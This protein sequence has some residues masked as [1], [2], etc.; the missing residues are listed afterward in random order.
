MSSYSS[1][2]ARNAIVKRNF[3]SAQHHIDY[4]QRITPRS[5]ELEALKKDLS[6]SQ[7]Q[8]A[9]AVEI[10]SSA[11]ALTV[12]PYKKPRFLGN[13][14]KARE[15]LRKAF[16]KIKEAREVDP[17]NPTLKVAEQK[18]VDKYSN[19]IAIHIADK[20]TD[21]ARQFLN[22]LTDTGLSK[23]KVE[24]LDQEISSIEHRSKG[25]RDDIPIGV[26]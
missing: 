14:D 4:V 5:S 15:T 2:Q 6:Y 22:D 17:G 20:D 24:V 25:S 16:Y 18:L 19:I 11:D 8:Q 9:Q 12:K 10:L 7:N 21:E 23:Q 26:F 13:N 3:E 1:G